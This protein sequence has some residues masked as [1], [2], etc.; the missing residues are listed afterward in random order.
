MTVQEIKKLL[1]SYKYLRRHIER[2]K[3]LVDE[4]FYQATSS[5]S[6][7]SDNTRVQEP[8]RDDPLGEIAAKYIDGAARLQKLTIEAIE[9]QIMIYGMIER[10]DGDEKDVVV[11]RYIEGLKWE[12][13]ATD[14]GFSQS[15]AY[16][17]HGD[18]LA[19]MAG[20]K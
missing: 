17:I 20:E 15:Y 11:K 1:R 8:Q 6:M 3:E 10:L 14:L 12:D 18:A 7:S 13:V 9:K 2:Q 16:R 5:P 19:T 4:F